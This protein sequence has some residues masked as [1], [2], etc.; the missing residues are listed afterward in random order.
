MMD[1]QELIDLFNRRL[2]QLRMQQGISARDMSLSLGRSESLI[3]QIE[4]R[5]VFPSM[6]FF[7]QICI[8]LGIHPKDFFNE[9]RVDS[10]VLN[11]LY[12]QICKLKPEQANHLLAFL[13]EIEP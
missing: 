13:K 10:S 8:F 4:N 5:K 9:T 2:T 7:F 11:D 12:E 6:S 3:N 1:E